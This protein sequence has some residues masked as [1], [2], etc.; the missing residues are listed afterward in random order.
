MVPAHMDKTGLLTWDDKPYTSHV[1]ERHFRGTTRGASYLMANGSVEFNSDYGWAPATS[2]HGGIARACAG[3]GCWH[4]YLY[5]GA[6]DWDYVSGDNYKVKAALLE[7]N[8]SES[9][10]TNPIWLH[11]YP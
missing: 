2:T 5:W 4:R 11:P 8:K 9:L 1:L 6:Y 10:M 7:A 3:T